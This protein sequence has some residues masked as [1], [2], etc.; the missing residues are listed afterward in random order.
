V[1]ALA[2]PAEGPEPERPRPESLLDPRQSRTILFDSLSSR[3]AD[4]PVDVERLVRARAAGHPLATLPRQSRATMSRGVQVLVDLGEGMLPFLDDVRQLLSRV[5]AVAGAGVTVLHFEGVPQRGAGG[6]GRW[7]WR[8]YEELLPAPGTVVLAV[9]DLGLGGGRLRRGTVR[10]GE[11]VALAGRLRGHGCP[12]RVVVP[13]PPARW[14]PG[15]RQ[16]MGIIP[17]DRG[18]GARL[19]HRLL[20]DHAWRG[21]P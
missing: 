6:G 17:W 10:S 16:E 8:P 7:C 21:A 1:E 4:G 3:V 2:L 19:V 20:R 9:T 12:L 15:L 13:Y 5:R 11:W 18:T 14:P